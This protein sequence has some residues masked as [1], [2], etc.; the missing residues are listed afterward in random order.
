[1]PK[2]SFFDDK[3]ISSKSKFP[4]NVHSET[5]E[6]SNNFNEFSK[7]NKNSLGQP[8]RGCLSLNPESRHIKQ[9]N[10]P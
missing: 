9:K 6:H 2:V 1:M 4:C 3:D 10:Q 7:R 8:T 5:G